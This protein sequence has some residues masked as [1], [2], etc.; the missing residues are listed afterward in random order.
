VDAH[1]EHAPHVEEA[2]PDA[3]STL[4]VG[5][6]GTLVLVMVVVLV[7]G[8]YGQ[9]S[10]AEWER[11]VVSQI[12]EELRTLRA[13]QLERLQQVRWVDR[14]RGL[15]TIPIDE[16]I[17]RLVASADPAAPVVAVPAAPAPAP[18]AAP[19]PKPKGRK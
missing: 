3:L 18:G 15:V 8:M 6:V 10:R 9:V 2:D 19:A 17:A 12:P 4:T 1:D 13:S 14:E 7:Q 5:I 16:A 11:K